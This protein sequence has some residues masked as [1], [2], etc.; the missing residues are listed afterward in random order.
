MHLRI[1]IVDGG[2]SGIGVATCLKQHVVVVWLPSLRES[3]DL[4]RLR[5][6]TRR[7]LDR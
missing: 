1:A 2:C 6:G 5:T 7:Q 3:H 4:T